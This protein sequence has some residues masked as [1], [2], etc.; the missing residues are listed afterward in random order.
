[1]DAH[2]L[3]QRAVICFGFV[4][5]M[6]FSFMMGRESVFME[7]IQ[8]I[9]AEK[10][11]PNIDVF[12][13]DFVEA[14]VVSIYDGDTITV[15]VVGW[16]DIIGKKIEVRFSGIDTPE[17]H[18]K[19]PHV[20]KKAILAREFVYNKIGEA[21]RVQLKHLHRDKYFRIDAEVFVNGQ[22]LSEELLKH[23]LAVKYH[24]KTKKNWQ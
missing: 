8:E 22:N 24:G 9:V 13:P 14:E 19:R 7:S 10:G 20:R 2:K 12:H 15:N 17:M 11:E 1:M 16:P 23:D 3:S 18:D 6:T 5:S 4:I 21:K